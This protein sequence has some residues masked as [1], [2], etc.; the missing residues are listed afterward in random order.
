MVFLIADPIEFV[1]VTGLILD[2]RKDL[3]LHDMP[4]VGVQMDGPLTDVARVMNHRILSG[5]K[6]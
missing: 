4:H 3:D 5:M 6:G 2:G 1:A